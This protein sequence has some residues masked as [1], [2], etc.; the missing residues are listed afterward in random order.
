LIPARQFGH[1]QAVLLIRCMLLSL[2]TDTDAA[3]T[4][5]STTGNCM[6]SLFTEFDVSDFFLTSVHFEQK[7]PSSADHKC[8]RM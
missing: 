4:C 3:A 7:L 2:L 1:E 6:L 5:E 8:C